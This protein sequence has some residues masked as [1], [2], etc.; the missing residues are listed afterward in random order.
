V[1]VLAPYNLQK[2]E[3]G[4]QYTLSWHTAGVIANQPALLIDAGGPAVG[5][6]QAD[7]FSVPAN[8]SSSSV[9]KY[10]RRQRRDQARAQSIYQHYSN[11]PYNIGNELAY[12][13]P[14]PDGSYT[15]RLHFMDPTSTAAGQ[16]VF[17]IKVNGVVV[18]SNYDIY[19]TTGAAYKADAQSFSVTTSGGAGILIEL[20]NVTNNNAILSGIELDSVNPSPVPSPTANLQLSTDG[21]STWNTIATNQ[22]LDPY[23]NG[24]YLWTAAPQTSGP[25]ALFRVSINSTALLGTSQ[26]FAI[27]NGGTDYYV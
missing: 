25:T 22:P 14:V 12:Q 20:V 2:L 8:P 19:A 3:A 10:Y 21:G 9:T 6:W 7:S 1:Q 16:R 11:A 23:G 5:I 26:P 15:L 24:S 13:L 4:H 17:N 27:Y 18:K